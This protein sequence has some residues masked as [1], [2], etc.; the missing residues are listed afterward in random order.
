MKVQALITGVENVKGPGKG[1]N[2]KP[3]DF[4]KVNFIDTE[5]PAG[6][7]QSMT[8]PKDGE[9]LKSLLPQFEAARMKTANINVFQNGSYTNFGGFVTA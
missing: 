6:T 2:P 3:Y 4:W 1:D 9:K 7:P 5:N 8:L